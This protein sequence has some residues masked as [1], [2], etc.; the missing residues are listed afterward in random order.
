MPVST[1]EIELTPSETLKRGS[2]A[3]PSHGAPTIAWVASVIGQRRVVDVSCPLVDV[4]RI[5]DEQKEAG[6]VL[7]TDGDRLLAVLSKESIA[8][9]LSRPYAR[10]L[11]LEKPVRVFLESQGQPPLVLPPETVISAA[12]TYALER[13]ADLRYE[14]IVTTT[15]DGE[16]CLLDVPRL[17]LYQCQ[18]LE[19][20]VA[21]LERQRAATAAAERE[22]ERLHSQLLDASRDAGR[23]EVATGILHNVGNVLNSINVSRATISRMLERSKIANL[24]KAASLIA[25]QGPNTAHFFSADPRGRELPSYLC[26]LAETLRGEHQDLTREINELGQNI[27][28]VKQVVATQQSYAKALAVTQDVRPADLMDD[29]ARMNMMSFERHNV[30]LERH[31][32]YAGTAWLDR[33]KVLQIL[34][35]L[36][37]NAKNAVKQRGESDRRISLTVVKHGGPGEETIRFVVEDNGIGISTDNLTSIFAHGFTTRKDGHGFGLHSAANLA[38]ELRGHLKAESDGLRTGARFTLDLPVINPAE[39]RP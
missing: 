28:H 3:A 30:T 1:A 38:K 36:I 37:S 2:A 27:E 13:G 5:L 9:A 39:K 4:V 12:I 15:D 17:L 18:V 21:A 6:G 33:H 25:E 10:Q 16:C 32:E 8:A 22:R 11:F 23:A 35:N 29:A 31:Y 14:P 34:I 24:G 7:V 20:T 26:R 19:E